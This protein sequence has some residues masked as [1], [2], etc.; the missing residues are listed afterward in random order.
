[1][2]EGIALSTPC[3]YLISSFYPERCPVCPHF[4]DRHAEMLSSSLGLT[5]RHEEM[6]VSTLELI[7]WSA[8]ICSKNIE[9]G[10]RRHAFKFWLQSRSHM[11]LCKLPKLADPLFLHWYKEDNHSYLIGFPYRLTE[12]ISIKFL[13]HSMCSIN[14]TFLSVPV[15]FLLPWDWIP[16]LWACRVNSQSLLHHSTLPLPLD[17]G[18]AG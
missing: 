9:L 12:I 6:T 13:A 4:V 5:R 11:T 17:I 3:T 10:I 1:M 2:S 15:I 7:W 8:A 16:L 14:I 18:M